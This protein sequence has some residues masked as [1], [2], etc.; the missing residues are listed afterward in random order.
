M[1]LNILCAAC[2]Q[3]FMAERRSAKFCGA[4][5]R[6]RHH[7]NPT[8]YRRK[9]TPS[10]DSVTRLRIVPLTLSEANGAVARWHRHHKPVRWHTFSLGA[11]VGDDLVGA[12]IVFRPGG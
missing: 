5:C 9:V 4:T 11:M 12:T 8:A 3:P 1:P 6:K 2:R 7:R 10:R